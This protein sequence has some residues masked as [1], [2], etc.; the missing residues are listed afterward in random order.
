M[1]T[2]GIVT[3]IIH[4]CTHT[5]NLNCVAHVVSEHFPLSNVVNVL[6]I[7][8]QLILHDYV[9]FHPMDVSDLFN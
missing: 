7:P 6:I 1:I 3:Y 5:P 2:I 8:L 4:K 9:L